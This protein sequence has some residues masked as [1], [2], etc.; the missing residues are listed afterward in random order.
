[1]KLNDYLK[2]VSFL[3][4]VVALL[5]SSAWAQPFSQV[6]VDVTNGS[7]TYTGQNSTNNPAG[8]G[9]K[10]TINA[11]LSNLSAGGTLS[12]A[13]GI[14]NGANGSGSDLNI[15]TTAFT[16]FVANS[17][18]NITFYPLLNNIVDLTA[19]TV[20]F[21][22][23]GGTLNIS[24]TTVGGAYLR[25]A[26]GSI[27]LG[28]GAGPANSSTI[29][30]DNAG[31]WLL[32]ASATIAIHNSSSF[33]TAAPTSGGDLSLSYDAGGSFT[34]GKEGQLASY[35]A[36]SITINKTAGTTLTFPNAI[37]T[38][39]SFVQNT[40]N[41]QFQNSLSAGIVTLN[42][43]SA[44]ATFSSD[45]TVSGGTTGFTNVINASIA[46]NLIFTGN[47]GLNN[48]A[49]GTLN[50]TG[51]ITT[52]SPISSTS[53]IIN[54][55]SLTVGGT[56]ALNYNNIVNSGTGTATFNGAL[57]AKI[58]DGSSSAYLPEIVNSSTQSIT[59]NQPLTYNVDYLTADR[60]F[61]NYLIEN[62]AGGSIII[63]S[64]VALNNFIYTVVDYGFGVSAPVR[65]HGAGTLTIGQI[66]A[67]KTGLGTKVGQF[68]TL[69]ITNE[70]TGG[71]LNLA[72]TASGS[73]I[74]SVANVS[75]GTLAITGPVSLT[76]TFTNNGT[77]SINATTVAGAASNTGPLT[78]NGVSTFNSTFGNTNTITANASFSIANV[79]TN[80]GTIA[81]GANTLT[82]SGDFDHLTNTGTITGSLGGS[83]TVSNSGANSFNGGTFP[84]FIKTGAGVTTFGTINLAPITVASLTQNNGT[85]T[86]AN[87][88]TLTT[89]NYT[90]QNLAIGFNL[91]GT[92]TFKVT[93]DFTRTVAPSAFTAAGTSTLFF[94]GTTAQNINGG[95]LFQA[96]GI[97]FTNTGGVINVLNSI[98]ANGEVLISASTNLNMA[99]LNL[100]LNGGNNRITNNG[101]YT[102]TEGSGGG[103]VI[104]GFTTIN[105]G[106][107][108]G[109]SGATYVIT[110]ASAYS[111]ITI[112]VGSTFFADIV[113][114]VKWT[115]R[116]YLVTGTLNV[117]SGDFSPF[118][119]VA[120]IYRNPQTAGGITT[121][122]PATFD[123]SNVQYDVTY[124][125]VLTAPQTVGAEIINN[126][127]LVKTWR[128][129]ATG[130]QVN[131]PGAD[132]NFGG[133][134]IIDSLCTVNQ[135]T[136][137]TFNLSGSVTHTIL[138]S[139]TTAGTGMIK[140][141]GATATINGSTTSAG[142]SLIGNI[143]IASTTLCTLFDIKKFAG[144][145]TTLAA[146]NTVLTMGPYV[147]SVP[148]VNETIYGLMTLGG[149]SFSVG[150]L[151]QSSVYVYANA[152]VVHT[153]GS[154]SI[155]VATDYF[156][157]NS[158]GYTQTGG[159]FDQASVGYLAFAANPQTLTLVSPLPYFRTAV[160]TTLGSNVTLTGTLNAGYPSLYI[161]TGGSIANATFNL[162]FVNGKISASASTTMFTGT[163]TLTMSGQL[164]AS[165][166]YTFSNF[167]INSTTGASIASSTAT[168]HTISVGTLFTMT[169]GS[170][171][172][173]INSLAI[174]GNFVRT[175]ATGVITAT[176]GEFQFTG[177]VAQVANQG[178]GFTVSNLTIAN[179]VATNAVTFDNSLV[180]PTNE[181]TVLNNLKLSSGILNT[182]TDK[183]MHLATGVTITRVADLSSLSK[184]PVFD[185]TVNLVYS[186]ITTSPAAMGKEVP[187]AATL[188]VVNTTV[189]LG[190]AT[191]QLNTIL[192]FQ[193]ASTGTLLL[194][195]GIFNAANV[196]AT[197]LTLNGGETI[198]IN[199]GF[200]N[201]A[202]TLAANTVYNL[203]Y[204]QTGARNAGFEYVNAGRPNVTVNSGAEVDFIADQNA[205]NLTVAGTFDLKGKTL[206]LYGNLSITGSFLNTV[207]GTGSLAFVGSTLQTW[208]VPTNTTLALNVALTINNTSVQGINLKG[209]NLSLL[210]LTG[211]DHSSVI[212]KDGLFTIDSPYWVKL[213]QSP[214]NQG[215]DRTLVGSNMSYFVG[216]VAKDVAAGG[217]IAPGRF[218]FPVGTPNNYKLAALT[219]NNIL[220]NTNTFFVAVQ[221]T[222]PGG[223]AGFPLTYNGITIDTTANFNWSIYTSLGMSPSQ[224]FDIELDGAGFPAANYPNGSVANLRLI[225]REGM[226]VTTN[227]WTAQGG[228]YANFDPGNGAPIVRVTNSQGN[229]VAFPGAQFTFGFKKAVTLST[230]SGK[231]QYASTSL[232]PVKN[233]VVTLMP[234]SRTTT[235]DTLGNFS[236]GN[237]IN[238][239]YALSATTSNAWIPAAV[240]ATD[241]FWCSQYYA[242]LRTFSPIQLL[243]GDVNLVNGVTN[244]DALLIVRRFAGLISSFQAADWQ[245]IPDTI[246]VTNANVS[247]VSI[248]A[249][250]A[251][252][253]TGYSS[254]LP[255]AGFMSLH[256]KGIAKVS[257]TQEFSVPVV[258]DQNSELGAM[259]LSITYP[260]NLATFEGVSS[261][262]SGI[263]AKDVNGTITIG[264]AD[265]SGGK[266][267]LTL[268]AGNNVL[269]LNFKP[270]ANFKNNTSFG[271]QLDPSNS[272]FVS[273]DGNIM[274]SVSL[275]TT[276]ALGTIPT[277]FGL[278]QNYP[279]PFN[280]STTISYSLKDKGT[281]KLE[282]INSLGQMVTTIVNEIQDAG[283]YKVSF[284]ASNL[285][286]G[287]YLYR[288]KVVTSNETFTK[289][290]K[291]MLMK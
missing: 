199:G 127:P 155:P 192:P 157:V 13:A 230:I 97:T 274:P 39:G 99:T 82:L 184:L 263:V 84:A 25:Q 181:F 232:Q 119:N 36:G 178:T 206:S 227:P 22:V 250:V 273:K 259:S 89:G 173:G 43:T 64:T 187:L 41:T 20:T 154:V 185:G 253:V 243:A 183:V 182:Q 224:L 239:T 120:A 128:V 100:I 32:P 174:Q 282:I 241:A 17:T 198:N 285:A 254:N 278:L 57:N 62:Q 115:G 52:Y 215:F 56:V 66:T 229:L 222:N 40:G 122:L 19:G 138:G 92:A 125:G 169:A 112:D 108:G 219:F 193:F 151:S 51:G 83:V 49:L 287:V 265:M 163:G 15:N 233:V 126:A 55:G 145:F 37:T 118:G 225:T 255:K 277:E 205:N 54:A 161:L 73:Q 226:F 284:N 236:F 281:V 271:I 214:S 80:S 5:T 162:T 231:V 44:S 30:L 245:F 124:V 94:N 107:A 249:L 133:I 211:T 197:A 131:L 77:G 50:I 132:L 280:P 14:Y 262:A 109:L 61:G 90:E 260:N 251:G 28:N 12:I 228:I 148:G 129:S 143:Q 72:G 266:E 71:T 204:S 269:V 79:L 240:N 60:A 270:T 264:W 69:D 98:R 283:N 63:N 165:N 275:T 179:T 76:G 81:L 256:E 200:V 141:S 136:G 45:V 117:L 171:D 175:T 258:I 156:Y 42:G 242:G 142:A 65:N 93:G 176:T 235:T 67:T 188:Q 210:A 105:G 261:I 196:P 150:T 33:T 140:V 96:G 244:G 201:A 31:S 59:F 203:I 194:K 21:N 172:L 247:N 78:I 237:L 10:A 3:F 58:G 4:F 47:S 158:G 95:T 1:M 216:I 202:I 123:G 102:A 104:G 167:A 146:S 134:L 53:F 149:A 166:N 160:A 130:N 7:D 48:N 8:S 168:P 91:N 46:G 6:Y 144:T 238:G 290:N 248:A 272:E 23:S 70:I 87:N 88:I 195:S 289:I 208:T 164:T 16:R 85:I 27:T 218:E 212:F 159:T 103:V 113:G 74:G 234:G 223:S 257:P 24:G 170:L 220:S 9:P 191:N 276:S 246:T 147:S 286:S 68:V 268:K 207:T 35:G 121:T 190:A 18:I 152:G 291:M 189:D 26:T 111:Y 139:L 116:L 186:N 252:D 180:A 86:V 29:N 209:G 135:V 106:V 288:L 110:G 101:T 11:G 75:G 153:A 221:D 137:A 38:T 279:N 114:P 217:S 34:V 213:V 177:S 267:P 2:K